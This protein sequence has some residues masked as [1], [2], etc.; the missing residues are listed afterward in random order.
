MINSIG[1][2]L[3]PIPA[4]EF[5]MGSP[6]P[7]KEARSDEKPQHR[8]RLTQSYYLGAHQITRGQFRQCVEATHYQTCAEKSW[9]VG[10]D[11]RASLDDYWDEEP[12]SLWWSPSLNQTD[13]HPV[14]NVSWKD[15]LA[16]CDWL[17]KQEGR[18]YRLPTEAEWEYACRAGTTTR[19][20]FGDSEYLLDE[21][22]W[23]AANSN[24]QS[25]PVGRKR[26]NAW[27]LH[28]MHGNVWE[29]C[30]DGY[31]TDYYK[32]S[33]TNDPRGP[34]Q[35]YTQ[36]IRGGSWNKRPWA[37]RSAHRGGKWGDRDNPGTSYLLMLTHDYRHSNLGFRVAQDA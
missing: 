32:E 30:L 23:Y 22:A 21:Y 27:G 19:Y 31:D 11:L 16:F 29:W 14:V 18:Q 8:V 1:M 3:R 10:Q 35:S 4:G 20:S 2:K 17:S 5:L 34:E 37:A 25:Q 33:P 7:D 26:P 13:D 12:E 28:D 9:K 15:S 36:V 24:H 6:D